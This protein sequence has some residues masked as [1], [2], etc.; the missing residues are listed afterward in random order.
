MR[1]LDRNSTTKDT[2]PPCRRAARLTQSRPVKREEDKSLERAATS[3]TAAT[4]VSRI[5]GL[6]REQVVAYLF[7]AQW[8]TDAFNIAFRIPNMLRDL[9]AEGALSAAFIPTFTDV[10]TRRGEGASWELANRV[11]TLLVVILSVI[12]IATCLFARPIVFALAPGFAATPGKVDLT[13]QMA[14]IM[15]PFLLF[16]ALASVMMGVLNTHGRFFVPAVAPAA[17]NAACI[18]C[19]L[20]LTPVMPRIGLDPAMSLAIGALLGAIGQFAIQI[21][22]AS[23]RGFRYRPMLG[24]D[25]PALR[26]MMRLMLPATIGLSVTQLS[27]LVDGQFASRYG[28]GPVSYLAFAFRLIQLPLGLFGVAIATANQA[29]VSRHAAHDDMEALKRNVARAVRLAAF[30]TLPATAG[31]IALRRPIIKLLYQHGHFTADATANTA[32][33]LLMYTVGLFAY[34]I[35]KIFVPTFYALGDTKIPVRAS[36]IALLTKIAINFPLTWL[37]QYAGLALSTS[38]AAIVNLTVLASAFRRKVGGLA[39]YGVGPACARIA[40]AS[41]VV[42]AASYAGEL[43]AAR[44]LGHGRI[45]EGIALI[46]AV[47]AGVVGLVLASKFLR[48]SEMDQLLSRFLPRAWRT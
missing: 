14:R 3:V 34:S 33:V 39:G 5:F 46:L 1:S 9:F 22:A 44:L 6:V 37:I 19:A 48:I 47:G 36:V 10:R 26:K 27:I 11:I 17:F 21:P 12:T 32:W 30:L 13:V 16:I 18:L 35:T 2:R 31:L 38:I 28:D 40:A 45:G 41:I 42:G 8:Q 43:G 23:S 20:F 7:G 24:W 4:F 25:D 29:A 15:S